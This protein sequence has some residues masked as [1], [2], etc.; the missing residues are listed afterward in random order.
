MRQVPNQI[1]L[2]LDPTQPVDGQYNIIP[3]N[4]YG[5]LY[6]QSSAKGASQLKIEKALNKNY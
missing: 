3:H 5:A 1:F 2:S 4:L 6:K